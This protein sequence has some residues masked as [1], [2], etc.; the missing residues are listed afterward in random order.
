MG[1]WGLVHSNDGSRNSAFDKRHSFLNMKSTEDLFF[2][3]LFVAM[4]ITSHQSEFRIWRAKI[5]KEEIGMKTVPCILLLLG[6]IYSSQAYLAIASLLVAFFSYS[7]S[8]S[9]IRCLV[10]YITST[11]FYNIEV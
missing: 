9:M 10:S 5:W 6:H 3:F 8:M 1:R 4:Y 11:Y 2:S 7:Y